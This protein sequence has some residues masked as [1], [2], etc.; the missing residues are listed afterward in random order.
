MV[1]QSVFHR[2][3]W[4]SRRDIS[5]R[6]ERAEAKT[7]SHTFVSVTASA[8]ELRYRAP[9]AHEVRVVTAQRDMLILTHVRNAGL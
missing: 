6:M 4:R 9:G 2:H 7:V 3:Q 8:I 1:A 5:V